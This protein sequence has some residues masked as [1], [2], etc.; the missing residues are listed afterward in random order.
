MVQNSGLPFDDIR[1]LLQS[2]P[3]PD[4][5]AAQLVSERDSQLTKPPGALG[6]LEDIAVWLATWTGRTSRVHWWLFSQVIM[7]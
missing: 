1:A 3:G 5:H 7:V 2:M 4:T 6:K